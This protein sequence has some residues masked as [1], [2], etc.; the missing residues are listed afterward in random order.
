[1][2]DDGSPGQTLAVESPFKFPGRC[3]IT[4]CILSSTFA[5]ETRRHRISGIFTEM[6]SRELCLCIQDIE[7]ALPAKL[8]HTMDD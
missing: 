8:Y 1:M 3:M 7:N 2:L 4:P 5:P 6:Y